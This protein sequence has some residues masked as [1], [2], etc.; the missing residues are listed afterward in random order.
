MNLSLFNISKKLSS[1]SV[2]NIKVFIEEAYNMIGGTYCIYYTT[3]NDSQILVCG[4]D[5]KVTKSRS[6]NY[7][8]SIFFN[9]ILNCDDKPIVISDI[10]DVMDH[11]EDSF[12]KEFGIKSCMAIPVVL[13]DNVVG[14]LLIVNDS[15]RVY[16]QQEVDALSEFVSL[17]MLEERHLESCRR[18]K[19]SNIKYNTVF[20]NSID[21]IILLNGGIITEVNSTGCGLFG[22]NIDDLVGNNI[23]SLIIE[24]EGDIGLENVIN[25]IKESQPGD[26]KQEE[27]RF[28]RK[29]SSE[30]VGEINLTKLDTKEYNILAIIRDISKRKEYELGL[31]KAEE[32]SSKANKMKSLSL[33]SMSHEIRTPLNSII[34]FSDLLLD[35]ETTEDEKEMFSKLIQTAGKSLMQLVG[36]IIDISK[37][38]AGQV[39]IKKVLFNVNNFLQEV[40]LTF[41]QEKETHDKSNIELKLVL[42]DKASELEIET[43]PHRLQQVFNNLLTNSLKFIDEG[44]IEFGYLS[45]TPNYIQFYVKDTGVGIDTTKR[46]KIFEQFGQDKTTYSRN[47]E[48]TGLG[49]S[50][51]KS[52][53][54]LLGGKIWLDSEIDAGSTFYFTIPL[55]LESITK[56]NISGSYV[57]D[58]VDWSN[59]T[60]VIA[61]D[62][63]ENYVFLKGIFNHTGINIIWAKNGQEAVDLCNS[64]EIDIVLMDIRMP[65]MD[66][67]K[68]SRLIKKDNPDIHII[69]QTAFANPEDKA[70][71]FKCGCDEYFK[72]PINHEKLFG[73]ISKYFE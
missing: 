24:T 19:L 28:I 11:D 55:G 64:N 13:L 27:V 58:K 25:F 9:R 53:V 49:L 4:D 68:A 6:H 30:F 59:Y 73:V 3:A 43:D 72:K 22:Y 37:I 33:A 23:N 10:A 69:A 12:I 41:R 14:C 18:Y 65:V 50:I 40:L 54:E 52:F 15:I 21:S 70:N 66:G 36:D 51:S 47:H 71:C 42:S 39:T 56:S 45:I 34:G 5:S 7:E 38:E 26:F 31:I 46:E 44:F 60:I 29:D 61:D 62:V 16:S 48:G 63:E 67:L 57:H 32:E 17:I 20:E 2:E 35:D 8:D 1:D